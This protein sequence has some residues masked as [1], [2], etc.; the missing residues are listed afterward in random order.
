[1]NIQ[2][3]FLSFLAAGAVLIFTA[4]D[5]DFFDVRNPDEIEAE[6]VDP[7]EF[8]EIFSRSAYQNLAEAYGDLAVY[9]GWF[10]NELWVGAT[11]PTRTALP[12]MGEPLIP[13]N[14]EERT[15]LAT[16][17]DRMSLVYCPRTHA[18]FHHPP[19]PIAQLLAAGVRVALGTD[20]RASNPDLDLLAEMRHAAQTHP[21]IDPQAILQMGTLAGACALGREEQA[22]TLTPGK[23]A[24]IVAMPLPA[25]AT[26]SPEKLLAALFAAEQD[27][28]R[29]IVWLRGRR[30]SVNLH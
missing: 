11:F 19:F 21:A 3:Y 1:M 27:Q 24:S 20:S 15:F 23:L 4:C 9:T 28:P 6:T 5:D 17:A 2:R 10:S 8:V 13:S 14:E 7:V 29:P 22:G 12:K 26:G 25:P 30:V 16:N 18:Y